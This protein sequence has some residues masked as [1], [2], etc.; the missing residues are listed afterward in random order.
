MLNISA[1]KYGGFTEVSVWN[2]NRLRK[3]EF[4]NRNR[5]ILNQSRG[6]G[7]WLWKPFIILNE[8]KNKNDG[9]YVVYSDCGRGGKY[10]IIT[11]NINL[12]LEWSSRYN[13]GVLPG[14]YAPQYGASKTWTKR[15]CYVLT[16]CDK[17]VFWEHCQI[18]ASFSIWEK[19][20][21]SIT[22]LRKW[23]EYCQDER[24]LTD[25]PNTCG[26]PNLPGFI[27]HRHDQSVLT[28]CAVKNGFKGFGNPKSKQAYCDD[29][30]DINQILKKIKAPNP[31][32]LNKVI[33][34]TIVYICWLWAWIIGKW[35]ERSLAI[36]KSK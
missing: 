15:D 22:F 7:Y 30:K 32:S 4:Y 20:E 33:F 31:I 6:A 34:K 27:E 23:L 5:K 35:K 9:D 12:L 24:M 25:I 11:R 8:L 29:D 19:N 16:G 1:L 18:Q 2:L 10:R 36:K 13:N 21:M 3:T 17:E 28:L 14:L 26:L